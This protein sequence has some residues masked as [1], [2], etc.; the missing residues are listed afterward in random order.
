VA[1]RPRGPLLAVRRRRHGGELPPRRP[2]VRR[3]RQARLHDDLSRRVRGSLAPRALRVY[4]SLDAA[5]AEAG[6]KL[7][8]SQLAIP[9]DICNAVYATAGYE[10][11]ATNVAQVSLESDLFFADGYA[12]QLAKASGDVESSI[13]LTLNVGV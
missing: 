4:E 13:T 6:V 5:G 12:S 10:Q 2:G 7:R 11:S 3:R 9:E 8:T 1:L